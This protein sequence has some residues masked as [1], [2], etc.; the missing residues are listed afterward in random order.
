MSGDERLLRGLWRAAAVLAAL[1]LAVGVF[2]RAADDALADEA[3]ALLRYRTHLAA[4]G[5]FGWEPDEAPS[6]GCL[7]LAQF[8][9]VS[10]LVV[11]VRHPTFA[12]WLASVVCGVVGVL[13]CV[14]LARGAAR[15][16]RD[17]KLAFDAFVAV[18]LGLAA[19][20][21]A[22][23]MANGLET[24]LTFAA[25]AS[26][27]WV[28]TQSERV[29]VLRG[30]GLLG[31]FGA[32]AFA[33]RPDLGLFGLGVPLARGCFA[34]GAERAQAWVAFGVGAVLVAAIAGACAFATGS[35]VP[36]GFFVERVSRDVLEPWRELGRFLLVAS[37]LLV[38]LAVELVL[39]HGAP[40]VAGRALEHAFALATL[41]FLGHATLGAL[42]GEL[43][44]G[45]FLLAALPPLVFLGA[46]AAVGLARWTEWRGTR[47]PRGA[48]LVLACGAVLAPA[49]ALFAHVGLARERFADG[50]FARF[51]PVASPSHVA[52]WP[53][54]VELSVL[55]PPTHD[56]ER[57]RPVVACAPA[58]VVG[59]ALELA[60]V[61]DVSG[62]HDRE[63]ARH[64]FDAERLLAERLPD[65]LWLP[66][67][68]TATWS[69]EL[70]ASPRL[71]RD[72]ELVELGPVDVAWRR[73]SPYALELAEIASALTA[74]RR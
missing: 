44:H 23:G 46:R 47:A 42:D 55:A 54:L 49:P 51:G 22:L 32:V 43:A 40:R 57:P 48:L 59:A 7:S 71:S 70:R 53:G 63:F 1:A 18:P 38:A 73:A 52:R 37:P 10:A 25:T 14:A 64:G 34:R 30:G 11:F 8:S 2:A 13:V 50:S 20:A 39:R 31:A 27:V 72:Y 6:F 45:R 62:L 41:A 28:W 56:A 5:V 60:R 3:F 61:I 66:A 29:D 4:D 17:P 58:G 33:V 19:P 26:L 68:E 69:R 65:W 15:S 36:L 67:P 16:A 74:A 12:P 24:T 35:P 21:L 9:W